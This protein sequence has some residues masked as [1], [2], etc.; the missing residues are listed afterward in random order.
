MYILSLYFGGKLVSA[1]WSHQSD[2]YRSAQSAREPFTL[3][4]AGEQIYVVTNPT[5][6][7]EVY[8]NNTSLSFDV[9]ISDLMLSCGATK[10]TVHK[11]NQ[12]PPPYPT[13]SSLSGL[14]P[15]NKSLIRLAIDFHHL[16][17]LQGPNSH[18][19]EITDT[20]LGHIDKFLQWDVLLK[21]ERLPALKTAES[22][23]VSLLKLCGRVLIE[24]GTRTYWGVRL[25]ELDP[26]MLSSFYELDRGIWKILFQYPS[27]FSKEVLAV[28]DNITETLAT[29]YRLPKETRQD[30]AW[31]TKSMETESREAGLDEN[32]MAAA[33]MIIYFVYVR[34]L[35]LPPLV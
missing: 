17:L 21:D 6:V 9:F 1:E 25:W 23:Q 12:V 30:A 10:E 16:Q 5:D 13:G 7:A 34:S 19:D 33:I 14:N 2:I 4:L 28:R 29:Y 27:I 35:L 31:F 24:A 32:E 22:M 26:D 20:F 3:T 8:K 11:M 18:A 15:G